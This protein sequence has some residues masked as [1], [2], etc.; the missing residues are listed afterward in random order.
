MSIYYLL[1]IV[2]IAAL[3]IWANLQPQKVLQ[4]MMS[5]GRKASGLSLKEVAVDGIVWPYLEG[6]PSNA[7]VVLFVHGFAA[8]KDTWPLYS[9]HFH[10]NYRVISPDL[11][12]FGDNTKDLNFDYGIAAQTDNLLAFLKA[13]GVDKCHIIGN[14]MGGHISLNF[15]VKYP[16][17]LQSLTLINNAGIMLED[18]S[19]I[20]LAVEAGE[21]PLEMKS[22]DDVG[23]QLALVMYK[24]IYLPGL[25]KRAM[26][27][28]AQEQKVILDK[29]FW[30]TVEQTEATAMNDSLSQVSV[31]TLILWG[32]HDR[33][34]DI[35]TVAIL[36]AGIPNAQSV[37]IEE[38]GHVPMAEKPATTAKHNLEF[39]ARHHK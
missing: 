39:I 37:I 6:G 28:R 12:G 19:D 10:K 14:S 31:P 33:V 23:R 20:A 35:S 2:L 9:K 38:A 11:P 16:Q 1:P 27:Q 25:F 32:R 17:H 26:Y 8:D 30:L 4:L 29:I 34:V 24:P 3:L 18:K 22:P 7:E 15:A 36:E 21:N 13:I 5:F